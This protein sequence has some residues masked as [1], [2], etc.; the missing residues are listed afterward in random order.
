MTPG[1]A[2]PV[3]D[4]DQLVTP[5]GYEGWTA[6]AKTT[7]LWDTL[8]LGTA[9]LPSALPA[10]RLPFQA[11][12][13]AEI[14]VVTR[15][16]E[17]EKALDRIDDLMEPGRPKVIHAF[18]AVAQVDLETTPDSPYTGL[19]APL[20]EGGATGLI[21]MSLVAKVVGKAAVTPAFG[22]KLLVDGQPSADLLA[23][24]HVV[25]Q[26]RDF[27]LFSNTMTNDLSDEHHEL[28]PPQKIMSVLFNRISHQPRRLVVTHVT[29]RFR[30]GTAVS[31]PVEPRR[32]VFHPTAEAKQVF[33]G[34]AGVDF[35]RVLAHHVAEGTPLYDVEALGGAGDALVGV[36][37]TRSPFVSSAGGDRLYFR[38]VQDPRDRKP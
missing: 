17:L 15:K 19:L 35:R 30:D 14:A 10:L 37:R 38:H 18:G 31:R 29:D 11:Q 23:M 1:S 4:P 7:W 33:A 34:Q 21:R 9:H 3:P 16:A 8:V 5:A 32:L 26:G 2:R 6:E 28:R 12:P 27:D 25:G 13:A 36:I 20:P 24:N 22:L